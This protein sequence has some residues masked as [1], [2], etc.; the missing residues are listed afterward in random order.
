MNFTHKKKNIENKTN[1]EKYII[2]IKKKN[3]KTGII[4]QNLNIFL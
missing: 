4:L 3:T 1:F 2:N